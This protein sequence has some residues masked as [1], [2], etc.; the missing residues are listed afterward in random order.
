MS[1][2]ATL[3]LTT[4]HRVGRHQSV[5]VVLMEYGSDF[6]GP[7]KDTFRPD[8][9]TGDPFEAHRSNFLHPVFYFYQH[10]PTGKSTDYHM[11][12]KC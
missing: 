2:L 7:E 12:T 6:S 9:A 3:H 8:R 5:L 1:L 4:G 11:M 10:L